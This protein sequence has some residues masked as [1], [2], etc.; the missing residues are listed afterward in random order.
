MRRCRTRKIHLDE[1]IRPTPRQA[2]FIR[3]IR[4]HDF[5]LYGGAAGGGK[6]YILRWS[7]L[8]L[9]LW[10]GNDRPDG[11]RRVRNLR[12][13]LFCETFPTL[14]DR[15]LARIRLEFPSWLG[16]FH[17]QSREFRLLEQLGGGTICFRNLDD[18][19]KYKSAEFAAIAVDE[20]TMNEEKVFDALRFRLRWPGIPRPKFLAATN[21]TGPGHLWVKRLWVTRQYPPHLAARAGQFCYVPAKVADNPHVEASYRENLASLPDDMRHA[22]LDGSWDVFAGQ[23]FSEF[24]RE[25]HT[26]DPFP[27]PAWFR[28]W[29][30]NDPGFGDSGVWLLLAADERGHVYALREW[31]FSRVPYSQQAAQVRAD[32]EALAAAI[33]ARQPRQQLR[34]TAHGFGP[35]RQAPARLAP[36]PVPPPMGGVELLVTGRDAFNVHPE[37]GKAIV[38]YYEQAGLV[39]WRQPVTDRKLGAATVHEYLRVEQT[40]LGPECR[41]RLFRP[42]RIDGIDLGCPRL[43]ETLPALVADERDPECVADCAEDHWYD[44]LRYGLGAWHASRSAPNVPE[45]PE[46]SLGRLYG[47]PADGPNQ[48]EADRWG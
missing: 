24:R 48:A 33:L 17:E 44:A 15:Q 32:L 23:V 11:W 14:H 8:W 28:R 9:L 27:P 43:I 7:L 31:T 12:V 25:I 4:A 29:L 30:A 2:E 38:H 16:A 36:A 5:V 41:L 39:G 22:L 35:A 26:L 46:R 3:A 45:F 40:S 21:P 47:T 20:L 34:P 1:L 18:P 10:W 19:E 37:T 42:G 6:S 13:G